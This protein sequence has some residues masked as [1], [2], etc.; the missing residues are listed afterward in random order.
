MKLKLL[1][2]L[3]IVVIVASIILYIYDA[4]PFLK[5]RRIQLAKRIYKVFEWPMRFYYKSVNKHFQPVSY[6]QWKL[7]LFRQ[8]DTN[9][10]SFNVPTK[11]HPLVTSDEYRLM[12]EIWDTFTEICRQNNISY[13]L[14]GGTLL[15][16]YRHHGFIPWDDDIDVIANK[17]DV[18][19]LQK[20][21]EKNQEFGTYFHP[22]CLKFFKVSGAHTVQHP[23]YRWPWIDMFYYEENQT[24]VWDVGFSVKR[25]VYFEKSRYFPVLYR[26]FENNLQ[27]VPFDIMY[28]LNQEGKKNP[29]LCKSSGWSHKHE[30]DK[31]QETI[32]CSELFAYYPFVYRSYS[33]NHVKETLK[34]NETSL[35][36]FS[37]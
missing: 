21:V 29:D 25:Q 36:A 3:T 17:R 18:M 14:Y 12:L 35:S 30:L 1:K 19:K 33:N 27:P 32:K 8:L 11:F 26:P 4:D 23:G 16:S 24:H 9:S 6:R 31:D 20:I 2:R 5:D 34:V 10:S 22:F 13:V 28:A 37:A 7:Q 15:G